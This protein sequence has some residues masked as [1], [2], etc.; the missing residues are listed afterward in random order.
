MGDRQRLLADLFAQAV[1]LAPAEREAFVGARC[2]DDPALASELRTLLRRDDPRTPHHLRSPVPRASTP[3]RI[4]GYRLVKLLGAGGMGEVFLAEQEEPVRRQVAIKLIRL[5]VDSAEI[6]ARFAAEQQVLAWL[7]HPNIAK[8]LDAGATDDGRPF[9]VMEFVAGR[10]LTEFCRERDL[11]LAAR[12]HLFTQVCQGV[13]HAHQRGVIH[14]DLKPSNIL[15]REIDGHPA[16]KI[17]DFGVAKAIAQDVVDTPATLVGQLVGTPEY[18]SPEQLR[19]G[20]PPDVRGDVYALGVILYELLAGR[21]PLAPIEG[22]SLPAMLHRLAVLEPPTMSAVA[23]TEAGGDR[24]RRLR[25]ELDW[26]AARALA[27]EPGRRYQSVDDLLADLEAFSAGAAVA[28]GPP[29]LSYRL[30]KVL[31]RHAG[32]VAGVVAVILALAVGLTIALWQAKEARESAAATARTLVQLQRLADDRVAESLDRL[33]RRE[34][35]PVTSASGA[36]LGQWLARCTELEGRLEMH[37]QERDAVA[38]RLGAGTAAVPELDQIRDPTRDADIW[39]LGILNRVVAGIERL[40]KADSRYGRASIERRLR[41]VD[42]L[43]AARTKAAAEWAQTQA[44]IA[45][46]P[47]YRGWSLPAVPDD[48]VP[49]GENKRTGLFEFWHVLS[50][51]RP[52]WTDAEGV[53]ALRA[54][55]GVVL[56]LLP[57]GPF[58]MGSVNAS[59]EAGFD[60]RAHAFETPI[61]EIELA[62]FF[63]SKFELTQAQVKRW[64]GINPSR[65]AAERAV[66]TRERFHVTPTNPVEQVAYEEA[67]S[68]LR[69]LGLVLPTEAQ[70][71]YACRAGTTTVFFWGDDDARIGEFANIADEASSAFF[72]KGVDVAVGVDDGNGVHA[73]VGSYRP[74]AFGLY[75]M[76]G[77]VGEWCVDW[78]GPY[79]LPHV[80][81]TGERRAETDSRRTRVIRGGTFMVHPREG[82]SAARGDGVLREAKW[83]VGLRPARA[84]GA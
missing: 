74:N 69:E 50:G 63:L 40:H 32:V 47:I 35:W 13:R 76:V 2:G 54:E 43:I 4:G 64:T 80:P 67:V 3:D 19:G 6:L 5:G 14:R 11:D 78:C 8:V 28:A 62:P 72:Q 18:M 29:T 37:R 84:I 1:E 58:K 45:A 31:R 52:V 12:L 77:N 59:G 60:P 21:R 10:T 24:A 73:P 48:L 15:V 68:L 33:A 30:S 38:A 70:W 75:D 17:I 65:F 61:H 51:E 27:R 79:A 23:A 34:L 44:V 56:V 16:P 46:S 53:S 49:L 41:Q 83:S 36:V 57:G 55:D 66:A 26:I 7:D 25:R 20:A 71:E 22:E 81:G 82:R 9:F 39:R 42:E